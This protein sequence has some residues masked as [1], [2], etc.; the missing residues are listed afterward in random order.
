MEGLVVVKVLDGHT[1]EVEVHVAGLTLSEVVVY[2]RAK[3][4]RQYGK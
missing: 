4:G 2:Q 3:Q 1:G